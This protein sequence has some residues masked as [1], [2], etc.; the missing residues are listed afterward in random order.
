MEKRQLLF[1][2]AVECNPGQVVNTH[3]PQSPSSII[4]YQPM[5]GAALQ[6]G[7]SGV[8]LN[9]L[10]VQVWEEEAVSD[11]W[12]QWIIIPLYKGKG[13]RSECRTTEE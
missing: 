6:L 13:S 12:R 7:R 2:I 5:G 3:V 11:E 1:F 10:F 4:W 8:A 9:E